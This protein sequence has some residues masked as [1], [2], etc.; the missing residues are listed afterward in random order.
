MSP[1]ILNQTNAGNRPSTSTVQKGTAATPYL[2]G[3]AQDVEYDGLSLHESIS[4]LD[5]SLDIWSAAYR[6][7]VEGLG[8]EIATALSEKSAEQLFRELEEFERE[9]AHK[10]A[11]LRGVE[12]LRSLKTPLDTFKLALD[13]ASPL[14]NL[15]PTASTVL[16]VV[17]SVTAVSLVYCNLIS[18]TIYNRHLLILRFSYYEDCHYICQCRY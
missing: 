5:A 2:N 6:E 3:P 9:A 8:E 4:S 15:E 16:G 17:R 12:R 1:Q 7:A 10:S 14:A 13:L 18:P 11:F